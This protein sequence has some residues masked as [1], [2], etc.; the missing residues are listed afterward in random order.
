MAAKKPWKKVGGPFLRG[1]GSQWEHES[2]W[3]VT[4]CGLYS[5]IW[6]YF[7]THPDGRRVVSDS[8]NG[9]QHAKVA[10]AVVEAIVAGRVE[11]AQVNIRGQEVTGGWWVTFGVAADGSRRNS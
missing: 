5:A 3:L 7:L 10:R 9:F 11:L 6:P 1:Q 4:H 2:G 8:G